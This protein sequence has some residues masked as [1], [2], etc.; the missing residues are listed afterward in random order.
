[1]PRTCWAVTPEAR[2][3]GPPAFVATLPPIEHA[4]WLEGSGA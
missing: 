2:Q 3:W 4:C 1:M